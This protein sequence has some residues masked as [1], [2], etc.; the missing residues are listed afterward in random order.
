[1][2]KRTIFVLS[3]LFIFCLA[4]TSILS[5]TYGEI[6]TSAEANQKFGPVLKSVTV[7]SFTLKKWLDQTDKY[8]MFKIVE[9]EAFILD[10]NRNLLYPIA[11]NINPTDVFTV[12]SVSV[13]N[14]LLISGRNAKVF[15]EQRNSVLSVS[16]GY[17]TMEVGV[18]CPIWCPDDDDG[19]RVIV[20]I[21]DN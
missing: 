13:I 16:S 10:N 11:G 18:L 3:M 12:F 15:V 20:T 6:F 1:M 7:P 19:D 21:D 9:D 14:E 8:I 5:Q 2:Y 17:L 4:S